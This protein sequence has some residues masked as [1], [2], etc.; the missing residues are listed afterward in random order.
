M[1]IFVVEYIALPAVVISVVI[2][3]IR[4]LKGPTTEDRIIAFDIF[5]SIGI[6]FIALYSLLTDS[7]LL[8]DVCIILAL[9]SFLGT[10]AFAFYVERRSK[11]N[12]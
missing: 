10:I 11:N 1:L 12:E 3:L 2:V 4:I 9:I 6:G 8:L 7:K 5:T